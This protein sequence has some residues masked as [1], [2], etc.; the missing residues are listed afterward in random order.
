MEDK[1]KEYI[2]EPLGPKK[3]T[4]DCFEAIQTGDLQS[5]RLSQI[6]CIFS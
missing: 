4:I 6:T 1:S 2:G 5:Y 3:S